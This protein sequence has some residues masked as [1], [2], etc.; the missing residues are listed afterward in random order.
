MICSEENL[1]ILRDLLNE[2]HDNGRIGLLRPTGSTVGDEEEE[3]VPTEPGD[4]VTS[5]LLLMCKAREAV[6]HHVGYRYAIRDKSGDV[7][8]ICELT[9]FPLIEEQGKWAIGLIGACN[10]VTERVSIWGVHVR[11]DQASFVGQQVTDALWNE[12]SGGALWGIID[13]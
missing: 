3:Y 2:W 5:S 13:G 10:P 9:A 11:M 4:M 6:K 12:V 8:F 7:P 1:V